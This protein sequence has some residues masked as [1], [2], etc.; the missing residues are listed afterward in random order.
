M[1]E[2]IDWLLVCAA[3]H[4]LRVQPVEDGV[5]EAT[6]KTTAPCDATRCA[7]VS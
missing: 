3:N 1:Y 6:L 7:A 2:R 5:Q 4:A